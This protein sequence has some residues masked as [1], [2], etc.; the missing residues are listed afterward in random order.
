M[1]MDVWAQIREILLIVAFFPYLFICCVPKFIRK[2]PGNNVIEKNKA[3]GKHIKNT[4]PHLPT[5]HTRTSV[6]VLVLG[7]VVC[8]VGAQDR[9]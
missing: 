2:A 5:V 6:K 3:V 8:L 1:M 4:I 9:A 7:P